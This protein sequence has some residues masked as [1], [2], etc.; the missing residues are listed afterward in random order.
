MTRF[1]PH[2]DAAYNLARWLM[3]NEHDAEDVVR[4]AYL[5]A[6]EGAFSKAF[7]I[8]HRAVIPIFRPAL[9]SMEVLQLRWAPEI[10]LND[11]PRDNC[12]PASD[13]GRKLR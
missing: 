11:D 12:H 4:E 8:Y 5:K 10:R 7:W 2:L 1:L 13:Q 9:L 6:P 3:R